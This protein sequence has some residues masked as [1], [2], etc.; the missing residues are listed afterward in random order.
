MFNTKQAVSRL[1]PVCVAVSFMTGCTTVMQNQTYGDYEQKITSGELDAAVEMA[2]NEAEVDAKTGEAEDLLWSLEAGALLRMKS[3]YK[4]ST[5]FFDDAEFL[6]KAEDTEDVAGKAVDGI[7]SMLLNDTAADYEQAHYDGIMANS[8]K[9]LNFMFEGDV[10]NARVEWNRVDDR[11]RRAAND[12][13]DKIA[14]QKEELQKEAEDKNKAEQTQKSV[15]EAE[16]IMASQGVDFSEWKAYE[17]YVN[18]FSTYMHGLFFMLNAQGRSDFGKAYESFQRAAAMTGNKIAKADLALADSLRKGRKSIKKVKPTVWVV[19]ENGLGPKREEFRIDLPVFLLSN[20]V[21]Y[22]GIALPKL[23]ERDQAY[24]ALNVAGTSTEVLSE[25][26]RVVKAE[27]K[28]EF[29]YILSRE[30]ARAVV[31]TIAQKQLNDQSQVAGILGAVAQMATTGADLRMWNSLPKDFQLA[32]ISKPKDGKL[33]ITA[34]GMVAPLTVEL[35]P[36]AQFSVVYVRA[37]S[38]QAAPAVDVLDI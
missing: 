29:P 25:M 5:A 9:A 26:D 4:Q 17:D 11:Q 8:Y 16:K 35:D 3:S 36:K 21:K 23:V 22:T 24:P 28:A 37:V 2:I 19:F 20:N 33:T 30:V 1:L 10:A 32:R 31:K 7:G 27:F 6:M 15:S 13:A 18:P 38:P 34:E 14:K 12:F